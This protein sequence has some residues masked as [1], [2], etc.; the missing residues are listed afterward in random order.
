MR[1]TAKIKIKTI[2][3]AAD[4]WTKEGETTVMLFNASGKKAIAARIARSD[5][6]YTITLA[7]EVSLAQQAVLVLFLTQQA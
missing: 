3:M 7:E 4:T 6:G 5:A 2:T 1:P